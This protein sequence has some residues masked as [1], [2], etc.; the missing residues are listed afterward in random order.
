MC[1]IYHETP[2]LNMWNTD[3]VDSDWGTC[4]ERVEMQGMRRSSFTTIVLRENGNAA[5]FRS[6]RNGL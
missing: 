5:T 6:R 3:L 1:D 2:V 4:Y